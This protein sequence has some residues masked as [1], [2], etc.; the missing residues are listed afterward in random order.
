MERDEGW[1]EM[2]DG[3][4]KSKFK[5]E[6]SFQK[7]TKSSFINIFSLFFIFFCHLLFFSFLF[8]FLSFFVFLFLCIISFLFLLLFC[9]SKTFF[10]SER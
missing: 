4:K 9:L 8:F 10:R 2:K 5:S 7:L 6:V 3:E 1:R